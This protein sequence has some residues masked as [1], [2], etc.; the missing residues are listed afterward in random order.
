MRV[1]ETKHH[2]YNKVHFPILAGNKFSSDSSSILRIQLQI[3][4]VFVSNMKMSM[5]LNDLESIRIREKIQSSRI[6]N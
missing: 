1:A 2:I 4:E 3:N 6:L 5:F